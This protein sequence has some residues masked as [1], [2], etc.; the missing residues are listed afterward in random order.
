MMMVQLTRIILYQLSI[1]SYQVTSYYGNVGTYLS[2]RISTSAT[3]RVRDYRASVHTV[4]RY[5]YG[6]YLF[7]FS[8]II[9]TGS[10]M[11][12]QK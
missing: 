10:S 6:R 8:N 5:F 1:G 11:Y 9:I 12:S 2:I 4:P 3:V 7:P